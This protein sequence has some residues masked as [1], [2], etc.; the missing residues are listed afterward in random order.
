VV[1]SKGTA[2][3]A[4]PRQRREHRLAAALGLCLAIVAGQAIAGWL[5][6][7]IGLLSDAGHNL[8]DAAGLLLAVVAARL[9]R[10]PPTAQRSFGLHRAT[11]LAALGSSVLI[12]LVTIVLVVEAARRLAHPEPVT[13]ALV[14]AVAVAAAI[15]NGLG[16]ALLRGDL[17]D[18]NVRAA[19]LH[20]FGDAAASAAVAAAGL[21][22]LVT[23]SLYRL[24]PI[25]SFVVAAFIAWQAWLL[26]RESIDV[27][28]E[29]APK[30]IGVGDVSTAVGQ[31]SGVEA[32][33]DLHV[34]SLSSELPALSAHLV[35]SGHP[36]LEQAQV[37][38][39]RV[40]TMLGSR[41]AI[42]HATLEL[43]CEECV[44]VDPCALD[45]TQPV[46]AYGASGGHAFPGESRGER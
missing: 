41:F 43:E 34:W 4:S 17:R 14:L 28:L 29:G 1:G 8:V 19:A 46:D 35:L 16:A 11:I 24:D 10:R 20:L 42:A 21:V 3:A 40:K 30:D 39:E 5:G 32:V 45:G 9:A 18:L 36:T 2:L 15:A 44:P 23:G 7:S 27:L 6:H 33:H 25:A 22:I 12:V 26:L 31:I 13:G 38:G 37:V